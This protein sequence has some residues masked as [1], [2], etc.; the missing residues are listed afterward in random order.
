MSCGCR[1]RKAYT[2]LAWVR[3]MAK[4]TALM[5]DAMQVIYLE[6]ENTY[7]YCPASE[8]KGVVY[9]YISNI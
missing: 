3:D 8:Y 4:K 6:G 9:E 1:N 5:T 7:N 2:N